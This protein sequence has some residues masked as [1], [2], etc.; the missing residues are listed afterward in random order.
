MIVT[1]TVNE[2]GETVEEA[3]EYYPRPTKD[4]KGEEIMEASAPG[5]QVCLLNI[6]VYVQSMFSLCSVY[7]QSMFSVKFSRSH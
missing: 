2:K 4:L 1:E 6:S 7:I 3:F 5:A